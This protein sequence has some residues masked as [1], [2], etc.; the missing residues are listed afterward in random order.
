MKKNHVL[1]GLCAWCE[2]PITTAVEAEGKQ[3][4]QRFCAAQALVD[5][6]CEQNGISDTYGEIT[7]LFIN[8]ESPKGERHY[9]VKVRG[10]DGEEYDHYD[11]REG[12]YPIIAVIDDDKT[13][14]W[15]PLPD[16]APSGTTPALAP[17]LAQAM[18]SGLKDTPK[19]R[20]RAK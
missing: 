5:T 6:E 1:S 15:V 19:K 14:D 17:V 16:W 2:R 7:A 4:C 11:D 18:I 20:K 13:P 9:A 10:C 12:F 8:M 3:Y